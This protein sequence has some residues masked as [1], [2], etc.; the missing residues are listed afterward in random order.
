MGDWSKIIYDKLPMFY[1]QIMLQ[2][3]MDDVSLSFAAIGDATCDNA[4]LQVTN[5]AQGRDIDDEIS[6]LWLV[7]GGGGNAHES[8]ELAGYYYLRHATF[9]NLPE[10]R[11]PFLFITGDEHFYSTISRTILREIVGD[12]VPQEVT[13]GDIFQELNER[14]HVFYLHKPYYSNDADVVSQWR[15]VLPESNVLCFSEAKA[16]VDVMLGAIALITATRNLD[17]YVED[18]VARG[19]SEHRVTEVRAALQPLYTRLTMM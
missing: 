1:G 4:P 13:A 19:Q 18:M 7:G 5:F 2:G 11:K 8:Y 3:Y 12:E 14:F 16:C 17:Q 9:P 6:K 10:G 15:S